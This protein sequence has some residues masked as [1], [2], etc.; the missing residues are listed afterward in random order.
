MKWYVVHTHSGMEN[1]AKKSLQ[2]RIVQYGFEDKFGEILVPTETIEHVK[3]NVR[4]VQ[5]RKCL[6]GYMIVQMELSAETSQLVRGTSKIAGFVGGSKMPS[7]IT[8]A[9]AER[10]MQLS[11]GIKTTVVTLEFSEGENVKVT[12]GP[13]ANFQGTI[14]EVKPEKKK[15]RVLVSIFGRSTPVELDFNQVEKIG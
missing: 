11:K 2:E 7:P 9:E 10:M 3:N 4:R 6:P 15:L 8:R 12:D 13:F 1:K 5:S 14:E